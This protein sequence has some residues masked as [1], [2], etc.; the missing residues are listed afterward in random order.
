MTFKPQMVPLKPEVN[1]EAVRRA[2]QLVEACE[3][4]EIIEFHYCA[5]R[6]DRSVETLIM[7][8]D[9]QMRRIAAVSRLLHRLQ[10]MCDASAIDGDVK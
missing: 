1:D 6:R 10:L 5:V 7:V 3:A 9:D 8:T 2:R 4:G